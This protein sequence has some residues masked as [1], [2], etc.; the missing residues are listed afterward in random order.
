M[1]QAMSHV[2]SLAGAASSQSG[3]AGAYI[4]A[5]YSAWVH[6]DA[7]AYSPGWVHGQHMPLPN[8]SLM[9]PRT[10]RWQPTDGACCMLMWLGSILLIS[11]LITQ[12][13][14]IAQ[15][16]SSLPVPDCT[17]LSSNGMPYTGCIQYSSQAGWSAMP[18]LSKLQWRLIEAWVILLCCEV[19][20]TPQ[21]A[22]ANC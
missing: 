6:T 20:I 11:G 1:L 19:H 9:K 7:E 15:H 2:Q 3:C 12:S 13:Y 17:Q 8:H 16:M 10:C 14:L 21:T 18:E 5:L 22:I 4:T